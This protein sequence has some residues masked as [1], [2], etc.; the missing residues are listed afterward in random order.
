MNENNKEPEVIKEAPVV[1]E[2]PKVEET[3]PTLEVNVHDKVMGKA[4]GPGQL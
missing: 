3:P 1:T 4:V 2:E